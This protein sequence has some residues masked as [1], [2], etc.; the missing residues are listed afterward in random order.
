LRTYRIAFFN[1]AMTE[2]TASR[3][4]T[5][6]FGART[7]DR[8]GRAGPQSRRAR[9]QGSLAGEIA[10]NYKTRKEVDAAKAFTGKWRVKCEAVATSREE[11]GDP[12]YVRAANA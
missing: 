2:Q 11:A 4:L 3:R 9:P 8:R 7:V 5:L 6:P 1:V 10:A 12:L